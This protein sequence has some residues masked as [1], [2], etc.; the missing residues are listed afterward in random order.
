M[1]FWFARCIWALV[2]Q[3]ECCELEFFPI[4]QYSEDFLCPSCR[5]EERREVE[6]LC[7]FARRG[8]KIAQGRAGRV[9]EKKVD[10]DDRDGDYD[11]SSSL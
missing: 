6:E 8:E 1:H 7:E 10:N 3:K 5:E 11:D 9:H 2:F 4:W